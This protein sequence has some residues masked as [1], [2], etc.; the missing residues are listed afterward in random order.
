VGALART[1]GATVGAG[2]MTSLDRAS[3][4]LGAASVASLAVAQLRERFAILP[5]HSWSIWIAVVLGL[6]AIAAGLT[7]R[8]WAATATGW[9]FLVAAVVQMAVWA[10]GD[11]WLGG[12]GS[13]ASV[14]LGLGVGLVLVGS[15]DRIWPDGTTTRKEGK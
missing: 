14:W 8:R 7:R 2:I 10:A 13:T 15:A 12:N 9:A 3:T 6:A 11:N 4:A 1:V 5:L